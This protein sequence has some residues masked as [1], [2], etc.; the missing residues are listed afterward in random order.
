[1]TRN[2]L[3]AVLD[4]CAKHV[5][6]TLLKSAET[7]APRVPKLTPKMIKKSSKIPSRAPL[8]RRGGPG[9]KFSG[10]WLH[11]G[12][13]FD[14]ISVEF[15]LGLARFLVAELLILRGF[16]FSDLA[17]SKVWRFI[18]KPQPPRPELA[19]GDVDPAAAPSLRSRRR[20]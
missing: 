3:N 7:W 14:Q 18:F 4:A 2:H 13:I 16:R 15:G 10:F 11:F 5:K 20:P 12:I 8:G 9:V 19:G 17:E 6:K 1:M